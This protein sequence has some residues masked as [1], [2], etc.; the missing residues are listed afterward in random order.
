MRHEDRSSLPGQ[1]HEVGRSPALHC[2]VL[3]LCLQSPRTPRTRAPLDLGNLHN[4]PKHPLPSENIFTACRAV[5]NAPRYLL[6]EGGNDK[7]HCLTMTKFATQVRPPVEQT[8]SLGVGE[9]G[10]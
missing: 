6:L 8:P 2:Q 10:R 7:P 9:E 3:S 1:H 5:S 4:F